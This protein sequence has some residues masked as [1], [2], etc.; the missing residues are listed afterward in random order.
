[1]VERQAKRIELGLVPAAAETED[2]AASAGSRE[3]RRLTSELDHVSEGVAQDKRPDGDGRCHGGD[4]SERQHRVVAE[5][6]AP[7]SL[8]EDVIHHPYRVEANGL[9]SAS[10]VGDLRRGLRPVRRVV[11]HL[12]RDA[13]L[14]AALVDVTGR[15]RDYLLAP[16]AASDRLA[17]SRSTRRRWVWSWPAAG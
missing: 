1:M 4:L 16:A 13:D 7:P 11:V 17:L 8:D 3:R 2:E 9:C 5:H 14:H 6:A 15:W 10:L 12:Q